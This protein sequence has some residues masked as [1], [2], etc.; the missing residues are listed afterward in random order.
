VRQTVPLLNP[1]PEAEVHPVRWIHDR[2]A[3]LIVAICAGFHLLL[4]LVLVVAPVQ[5]VITEGTLPVFELMGRYAWAVWFLFAGIASALLV[6]KPTIPRMVATWG[7]V[8][9][10][11][12]AWS[13]T[14]AIS[15][16]QGR[17]SA[18][19]LVVWPTLLTVFA[20]AGMWIATH[21]ALRSPDGR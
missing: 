2:W 19:G 5:T 20:V 12:F 1:A 8:I 14:F 4:A 10:L 21:E 9:P 11:G 7:S 15:V 17:G 18:I 6:M 3:R 16:I 13:G